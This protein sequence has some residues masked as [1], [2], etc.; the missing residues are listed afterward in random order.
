MPDD[1]GPDRPTSATNED[2]EVPKVKRAR[3]ILACL[4]CRQK[5]R[6]CDGERPR[7]QRCVRTNGDCEY[8]A[9]F[10]SVPPTEGTSSA[11]R[12][13]ES[14]PRTLG[15]DPA[16]L[17]PGSSEGVGMIPDVRVGGFEPFRQLEMPK[18]TPPTSGPRVE[19]TAG[20]RSTFMFNLNEWSRPLLPRTSLSRSP[21]DLSKAYLGN[22]DAGTSSMASHTDRFGN[23]A[24]APYPLTEGFPDQTGLD[25]WTQSFLTQVF[26]PDSRQSQT[27]PPQLPPMAQPSFRNLPTDNS[28]LQP[29]HNLHQ[30]PDNVYNPNV[31]AISPQLSSGSS[32]RGGK[33]RIPYF[34]YVRRHSCRQSAHFS[35]N[36][37]Q[38]FV[39]RSRE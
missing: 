38:I 16:P 20:V 18:F 27:I 25:E 19:D 1:E 5:K 2:V 29:Q 33:Y 3:T 21:G 15:Q 9:E 34:R 17:L 4:A 32:K 24:R 35:R 14:E 11:T 36:I 12:P 31:D 28:V 22:P 7:C 8:T 10:Y 23:S 26:T 37:F 6:R 39:C 30:S 13:I